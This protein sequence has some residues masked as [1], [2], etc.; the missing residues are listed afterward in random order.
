M[1]DVGVEVVEGGDQVRVKVGAR[2]V[3]YVEGVE[4]L[5][6]EVVAGEKGEKSGHGAAV[7]G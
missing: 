5:C 4:V 3:L 2:V 7:L 6:G 1:G